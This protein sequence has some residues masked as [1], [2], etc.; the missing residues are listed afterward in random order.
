MHDVAETAEQFA[1]VGHCQVGGINGEFVPSG[2]KGR[3]GDRLLYKKHCDDGNALNAH[4][5][6]M[7]LLNLQKRRREGEKGR[8]RKETGPESA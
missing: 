8:R 1:D 5:R 7:Q 2:R 4:L 3:K 6:S